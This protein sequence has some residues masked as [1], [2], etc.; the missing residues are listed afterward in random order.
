MKILKNVKVL[1]LSAFLIFGFGV[2]AQQG[3][4]TI[5]SEPTILEDLTKALIDGKIDSATY[6]M[7]VE[8]VQIQ[9]SQTK[10][11]IESGKEVFTSI[12]TPEDF[13]KLVSW[14]L[15]LLG[16]VVTALGSQFAKLKA[17]FEGNKA[18]VTVVVVGLVTALGLTA[19]KGELNYV[20]FLID[21]FASSG[22]AVALFKLVLQRWF[23]NGETPT[24]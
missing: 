17:G 13:W 5:I 3:D 6:K 18:I 7:V 23:G 10:D 24:S 8:K 19:L 9:V 15:G 1:L 16:A 2:S 4:S 11:F 12:D 14:I 20:Q 21:W 22:G